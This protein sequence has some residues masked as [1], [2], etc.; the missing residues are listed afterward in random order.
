MGEGVSLIPLNTPN[1]YW[2][3][4]LLADFHSGFL[5]NCLHG[6][7]SSADFFSN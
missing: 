6:I 3:F 7:L 5:G 2:I 1:V 4:N